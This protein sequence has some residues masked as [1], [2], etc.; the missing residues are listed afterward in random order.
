MTKTK[1]ALDPTHAQVNFKVRHL[2]IANVIGEF[3]SFTATAETDGDDIATA[4]VHFTADVHS[5]HTNNE[6]RDAHLR[7]N[8]FFDAEHN[9][10][11]KF[12]SERMEKIDN[13]HY[14]MHG[15]LTMR[16]ISKA[17]TFNVE[18]NGI[19]QD[20]WG[21]TRMGVEVTGKVN[22]TDYGVSF[23]AMTDQ[24]GGV[25]VGLD[26]AITCNAEMVK[27]KVAETILA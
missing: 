15:M 22:R 2:M 27:E 13:T 9:P 4:K 17:E 26:V 5:I 16:G 11:I 23:G 3:K 24:T 8:D 21:N 6:Q 14:K 10:Q 25:M 19:I 12:E 1:W 20:P 18:L 7:A